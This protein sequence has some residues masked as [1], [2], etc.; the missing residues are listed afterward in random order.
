M[1]DNVP[2]STVFLTKCHAKYVY[3]LQMP[4]FLLYGSCSLKIKDLKIFCISN[5]NS[6]INVSRTRQDYSDDPTKGDSNVQFSYSRTKL[7][8]VSAYEIW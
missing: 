6:A 4:R 5:A 1:F 3:Y 2:F 7:T 8:F